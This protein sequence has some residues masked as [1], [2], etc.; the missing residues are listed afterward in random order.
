MILVG[1][2][3]GSVS[4]A[5]MIACSYCAIV[6]FLLPVGK[7]KCY[8]SKWI[9]PFFRGVYPRIVNRETINDTFGTL[10]CLME[11]CQE[12]FG[13]SVT[14]CLSCVIAPLHSEQRQYVRPSRWTGVM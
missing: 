1:F 6:P 3:I 2:W 14:F 9:P 4:I 11:I 10:L 7:I 12:L 13:L 8:L 5:L